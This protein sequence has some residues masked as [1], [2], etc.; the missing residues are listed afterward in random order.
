M[1][2]NNRYQELYAFEVLFLTKPYAAMS[3]PTLATVVAKDAIA[4]MGAF[5]TEKVNIMSVKQ[6]SRVIGI[7]DPL[8]EEFVDWA[9]GIFEEYADLKPDEM[10]DEDTRRETGAYI[11]DQRAYLQSE[12]RR[13]K[14]GGV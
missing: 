3:T 13:V 4:A 12:I 1:S 10:D 2:R 11:E 7:V 5:D 9:S 14:G 6:G 8:R